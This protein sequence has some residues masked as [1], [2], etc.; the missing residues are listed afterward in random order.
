MDINVYSIQKSSN[1]NFDNE[2][3][4]YAKMALKFA[5]IK[6]LVFFNDKIAKA[7][8]LGRNEALKAYD[9]LYFS[10]MNQGYN[11]VLDEKGKS[12]DSLEF[13]KIF[14]LNSRINFFIGGAYGLSEKIK[15]KADICVSLS[16]MTMAHKIAKL[17]LFEQIFRGLCIK[18]GH[19]YHK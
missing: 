14:E 10:Y 12:L 4:G 8:N 11:V 6:D 13:A 7:Q 3:K 5:K 18:A 9:E 2:I 19:P 17:M 1:D 16:A 15:Q